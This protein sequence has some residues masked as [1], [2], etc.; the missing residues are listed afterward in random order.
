MQVEPA[1]RR[2]RCGMK[3]ARMAACSPVTGA[4]CPVGAAPR[5]CVVKLGAEW[6]AGQA[7]GGGAGLGAVTS[8]PE[9]AG[10]NAFLCSPTPARGM[11][12]VEL[13]QP[14]ACRR[15]GG[16]RAQDGVKPQP[17]AGVVRQ[18]PEPEAWPAVRQCVRERVARQRPC[19]R[20]TT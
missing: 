17:E 5:R 6:R 11:P 4:A 8:R 13:D 10:L 14:D 12:P 9:D 7:G 1:A 2:R 19:W 20:V 18:A 16:G 3:A 15:A